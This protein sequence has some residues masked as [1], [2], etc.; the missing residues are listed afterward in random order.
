MTKEAIETRIS[1]LKAQLDQLMANANAVNGA[2]QECE[3][4]LSCLP[5]ESPKLELVKADK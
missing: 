5:K 4:W 3:Y 2:I 1:S